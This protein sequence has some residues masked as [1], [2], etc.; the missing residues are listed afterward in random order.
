MRQWRASGSA[1]PD[2]GSL[3]F[4]NESELTMQNY[5]DARRFR[6]ASGE[7][8]TY[9]THIWIDTGNRLHFVVDPT[10]RGIEVGYLG[11]HLKTWKF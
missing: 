4:R 8:A 7:M 3:V 5:G 2:P 1:A 6:S 10:R 11:T 9:E